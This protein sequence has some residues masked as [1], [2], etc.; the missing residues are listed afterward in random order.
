MIK[1]MRFPSATRH[2]I[3][4][5]VWLSTEP[6][7]L[8]SLAQRWFLT[9]RSCGPDVREL[10]HD[11]CPTACVGDAAFGYVNVFKTHINIGFFLGANLN[12]PTALLMGTGKRMRHVKIRPGEE[13]DSEALNELIKQAYTGMKSILQEP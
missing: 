9:L 13:L 10:M 11:G 3:E 5:D 8:Y 12:D 2:C 6:Y 4:I 7:Q 1:L